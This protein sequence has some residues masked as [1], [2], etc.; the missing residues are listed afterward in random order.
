MNIQEKILKNNKK[1]KLIK[2]I[3][4][5]KKNNTNIMYYLVITTLEIK[6]I[7]SKIS[8]NSTVTTT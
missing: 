6:K 4:S 2:I 5:F 7:H 1:L 8:Q 3:Y